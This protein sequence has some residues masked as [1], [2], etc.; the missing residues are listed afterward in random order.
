MACRLIN[1]PITGQE[2]KSET[3][4]KIFYEVGD[5]SLSD[6]LYAQLTSE[7]FRIWFGDWLNPTNTD[8]SQVRTE[9][10]E[11]MLLFHSSTKRFSEF[12]EEFSKEVGF[13]F[14]SEIAAVERH[15]PGGINKLGVDIKDARADLQTEIDDF[16]VYP[17]FLNIRNMIE[18]VDYLDGDPEYNEDM[19]IPKDEYYYLYT[20]GKKAFR[21]ELVKLTIAFYDKG[22]IT[23]DQVDSIFNKELK[24][25][26]AL[27][28]DGYWYIN[29]LENK[30]EKSYV[31]FNMNDIKS[32]HNNG[33]YSLK[34]NDIYYN[35]SENQVDYKLKLINALE[36]T[37]RKKYPSDSIQG[38]FNDL[39]KQGT[40]K[41]QLDILKNYITRNNIQEISTDDLITGL[42]A[43][44]SFSVEVNTIKVNTGRQ[45]GTTSFN[46]EDGY[47]PNF[48][49]G[50]NTS[51][52]SNMAVQGGTNYTEN[53]IATPAI[54]PSIKGH[55]QFATE[56]GIG[57]FR[58]DEKQ[59]TNSNP[60]VILPIGTS[61][62]GKS[63]FIKSLPQENLVVIE[64]D[65]M[66]VEFTGDMNDKSKDKEIYIEAANRAIQAIKNGK[67]VVF[68]TTNLTKDKRLPFIEAIKKVIPTANIQYKLM[69]LN[70]E[71]AKQRIK[72][73][74]ARGE[75]RA[76]VSDSTI[77]RH[78]ESYK[79]MLEDIKNEPISP[80]IDDKSKTRR[81]LEVQSDIFQKSRDIKSPDEIIE[82]LKKEGKLKVNC[83]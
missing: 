78:A 41:I 72:A 3:W 29:R 36:K 73:Q 80:F 5:I 24:L 49:E 43:E 7:N 66:R 77:D 37:P 6:K 17:V 4:D 40:P 63:T 11:P 52:Y 19:N 23:R 10:G 51:Y 38:F 14:G 27:N 61:G 65:A 58:S 56:N 69:E 33:E 62:S 74:L 13:H 2:I 75:N 42:L 31:V 28:A 68:D 82:Q 15:F 44:S 22:I 12:K 64:P 81:I 48:D 55:A 26:D 47:Q 79:Q 1:S 76:N 83:G 30:G 60:D 46:S 53:E 25:K 39:I 67:Q 50:D 70:P 34:N 21:E 9:D 8:I 57:W 16:T 71:L 18:G 59:K 32:V 35:L 54:I 45:E 20:Q